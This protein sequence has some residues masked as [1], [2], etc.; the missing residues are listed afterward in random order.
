MVFLKDKRIRTLI[1]VMSVLVAIALLI[2]KYYYKSL[3]DSVDP[4]VLTARELY[5]G[6]NQLAV[7]NDFEEIFILLDSIERIYNAVPHY[8][9]SYEVGVLYNNRAA[10]LLTMALYKDSISIQSKFFSSLPADTLWHMAQSAVS[11]SINIYEIWLEKYGDVN[12]ISL[13][14]SVEKDFF[15]GL[16]DYSEKERNRFFNN[17]MKEIR[18]ARFET[19]RRLSVSYTNLGLVYRNNEEYEKAAEQYIKALDLWDRNLVAENNLNLLLNRPLK[20][21][22]LIQRIFPPKKDETN[23]H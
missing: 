10:A 19:P 17:R 14:D 3:N 8:K 11:Q 4:R 22:S 21:R 7:S 20:K 1:L 5:S 13:R 6:Y 23:N 16:D 15:I 18:D 9:N 2:T 12:E